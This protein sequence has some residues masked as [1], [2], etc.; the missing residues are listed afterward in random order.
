MSDTRRGSIPA[1][2]AKSIKE[3]IIVDSRYLPGDKVPNEMEL[4]RELGISRNS[5]R[6]A[7]KILVAGNVLRV[8][9]GRGTFV[10]N[11]FDS[12]PDI[13]GLSG[14]QDKKRLCLD[15]F[16]V[17]IALEPLI[18]S[19]AAKND[20][21]EEKRQIRFWERRCAEKIEGREGFSHED[22][23]FHRAIAAATHNCVIERFVPMMISA[24]EDT[25]TIN[26]RNDARTVIENAVY[27]HDS[28]AGYIEKGNADMAAA[29]MAVHLR[30]GYEH[31]KSSMI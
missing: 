9:R 17:R 15:W 6:E 27:Y 5:V 29:M 1:E 8:E 23:Q 14:I 12:L 22:S 11:A 26:Y 21:P 31:L 2:A 19:L 3:M 28:I 13:F 10:T 18:A 20:A 30:L 7:V 4:A 25:V 24:V 16:E